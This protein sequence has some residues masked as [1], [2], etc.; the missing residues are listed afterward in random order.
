MKSSIARIPPPAEYIR[1][2]YQKLVAEID[3]QVAKLATARFEN[4]LQ[5]RRGCDECCMRFSVLPLEAS[6]MTDI[7]G[8]YKY[9]DKVSGG[10]K[11]VFLSGSLC[12]LYDAR[13]IICRT[14]GLPLGYIDE[15][16]ES[17][18][19]SVCHLNFPENF[20]FT[21]ED[22]L[23]MDGINQIL[24]ELNFQYC[25]SVSLDPERRFDLEELF[26]SE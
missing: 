24:A 13:P 14:Q 1:L 5:C 9:L 7:V 4:V 16:T 19:V 18:E 3:V 2:A 21:H 17:I 26:K 6:V 11:C 10:D 15:V 25:Q 23:Y 8:E 12:R 20:S 22:L